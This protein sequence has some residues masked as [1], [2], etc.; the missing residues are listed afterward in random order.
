MKRILTFLGIILMFVVG[1]FA[2]SQA[3]TGNI[4]GRV[5]DQNGAIVPN[6]SVTATNQDTGFGKTAASDSEGN[7]IFVLL[8]PGKYRVE[9][10]AN[11]FSKAT[12]ENVTVTVGSKISLDVSLKVSGQTNVV[13]VQ[14]EGVA[15]ETTRSSVSTTV[16]EKAID[17]LPVNGRNFL[18]FATLTPGVIRDP[19]RAGDLSVGGQ[20]GTLNSLQIDGTSNDNTFFGQTL[21]R[22][23]TGRAPF[24]FSIETVKEFQINQNGFSAEFGRAGGAIINVV[25]KS[26]TNKFSGSAFEYFRD[27]SLNANTSIAKSN[28]A[29]AGRPNKRPKSQTNQFGGTFGGPIKQDKAFFFFAY[30]GQ[31]SDLPNIILLPSLATAPSAVQTILGPKTATYNLA[32]QQDVFLVKTDFNINEKN[33]LNIRFNQQNFTGTNN[34]NGGTLSAQEHSGN[35]LVNTTTLTAALTTSFSAKYFN[36]FRF[37]FSRDREPGEAN[38]SAVEAVITT[39]DGAFNIGRN[40]FSPRETTVKRVQFVDNQTYI[41][42]NHT[43]KYGADILVDRIFNFFPGLF[44]GSYSFSS[45][46]NFA[47]N[48]PTSYRQSFAGNGTTGGT[49]YP[50]STETA[51]FFQDDWKVNKNVT[52]N[53]GLRYDYQSLAKPPVQNP[54]AALLAAGFDTSFRPSDKNNIAPRFGISYAIDEKTVIRGG[55]GI[56]YARTPS[57]ITGTAH[58]Q[59]GIQVI[60]ISLTCA[61]TTCPTYP[62]TLSTAPTTG[63][64]PINLFLF[65]KDYKQP[66]VHQGRVSF[67]REIIPNM[68]VSVA[69]TVYKGQDLT[70]TRD[71]NLSAPVSTN[72]FDGTTAI[73]FDRFSNPRRVA[74]FNRINLFESTAESFYQGF[75]VEAKRRFANKFSFIAAYTYSSA[76]DDKPDQTAVVAGTDDA[77]IIQ[78]QFAEQTEYGRSD[79]DLKHR[80]VFSPV[81]EVGKVELGNSFANAFLSNW[82]LSGILQ[83]QSGFAYSAAVTGNPNNDD[84]TSNDRV[85]GFARN[86]FSTPS[87]FQVDMRLQRAFIFGERYKLTLMGEGFNIFNSSNVS[88]VN[89]G[90]YAATF[91]SGTGTGTL[92][93]TLLNGALA[94]GQPRA[95]LTERQFQLGIKFEF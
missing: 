43:L 18:D 13:D 33:Q 59:N 55:Y 48:T 8:P 47:A 10:S 51:F 19:N 31:R 6:A 76:K 40:N 53:L 93:R 50:N 57:I 26:G 84:N 79:L 56:F 91:N 28:A 36:E 74:G 77:K 39:P 35:S 82:V 94:F 37:Q 88:G 32:R 16:D 30:D 3:T 87:T 5:I 64:A 7:F 95:F 38:S 14:A 21:G 2:Q 70:R 73:A 63:L 69:Y 34:E 54:N 12:Y 4:E 52:L 89:N 27:E 78:N 11:G 83:A 58:S 60:G 85:P 15:V 22:T 68:T 65:S 92:T 17:N 67:E 42:G 29:R 66:F 86:Q 1:A 46:A 25:T 9:A 24:Q 75:S 41:W 44:S 81:Y 62:N 71:A 90:Y 49:T 61:T 45:Y 23:G 72:F 20:K 80:F